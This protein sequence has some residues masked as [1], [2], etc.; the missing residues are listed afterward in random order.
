MAR[1]SLGLALFDRLPG[2]EDAKRRVI[3][4]LESVFAGKAVID[5]MKEL[6]L[7]KQ[8][9]HDVRDEILIAA[10]AGAMP[11]PG[12]RPPKPAL[13]ATAEELAAKEAALTKRENDLRIIAEGLCVRAELE[14][15]LGRRLRSRRTSEKIQER[16]TGETAGKRGRLTPMAMPASATAPI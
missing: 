13:A 6:A 3:V 10:I 8:R 15:V 5:G 16:I 2:D 7:S 4:C 14:A 9:F 12:G 1:P 11:R